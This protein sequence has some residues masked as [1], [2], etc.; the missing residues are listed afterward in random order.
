MSVSWGIGRK[1]ISVEKS[2]CRQQDD[3]RATVVNLVLGGH[4]AYRTQLFLLPQILR[5]GRIEHYESVGRMDPA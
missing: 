1:P 4:A 3:A 5:P 2:T